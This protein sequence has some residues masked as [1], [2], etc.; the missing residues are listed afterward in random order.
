MEKRKC[1]VCGYIY[2]P[3][4]GEPATDIEPGTVFEDLPNKWI[5]PKCKA[6][7]NEFQKYV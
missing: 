5:C 2:N 1:N 7:K 3:E 6:G 4:K